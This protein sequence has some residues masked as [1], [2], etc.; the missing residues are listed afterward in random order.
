[1]AVQRENTNIFLEFSEAAF[2]GEGSGGERG[3]GG[4]ADLQQDYGVVVPMESSG[5]LEQKLKEVGSVTLPGVTVEEMFTKF[6][7][8]IP[9]SIAVQEEF[10]RRKQEIEFKMGKWERDEKYGNL[11]EMTYKTPCKVRMPGVPAYAP[12]TE[13]VRFSITGNW[14]EL[15][16]LVQ[17]TGVPYAEYFLAE[18]RWKIVAEGGGVVVSV[19]GGVRFLKKT[20]LQGKIEGETIKAMKETVALWIQQAQNEVL[21]EGG[22][23]GSA[24]GGGKGEDEV[25]IQARGEIEAVGGGGGGDFFDWKGALLAV[26]LFLYILLFIRFSMLVTRVEE[27]EEALMSTSSDSCSFSESVVDDLSTDLNETIIE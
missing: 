3:A 9:A 26:L 21:G 4:A 7:S 1:M 14:L 13:K 25:A 24:E 19:Y 12:V 11:K 10:H 22:G 18:Q 23:K 20:W 5:F 6:W 27:L 2:S 16:N 15:E 8:D 17:T